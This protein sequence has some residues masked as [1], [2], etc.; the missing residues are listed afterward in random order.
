MEARLLVGL[1]TREAPN[2]WGQGGASASNL[3]IHWNHGHVSS[4][5]EVFPPL[6]TRTSEPAN[7]KRMCTSRKNFINVFRNVSINFINVIYKC[8]FL[9]MYFKC[10]NVITRGIVSA[11]FIWF[12]GLH[13]LA[14]RE[15]APSFGHRL[16]AYMASYQ[17]KPQSLRVLSPL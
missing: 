9:C 14:L 15:K 2:G 11:S 12:L 16:K 3:I 10:T 5:V 7:P 8:T 17:I 13:I 1:V 4:L 6:E